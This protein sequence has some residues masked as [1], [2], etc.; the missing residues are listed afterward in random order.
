MS[1]G[2][3]Q[4]VPIMPPITVILET[5]G[6]E[7]EGN[8]TANDETLKEELCAVVVA[9]G[10]HARDA[11]TTYELHFRI[12][13][14]KDPACYNRVLR[15][16]MEALESIGGLPR[17]L[18]L[19]VRGDFGDSVPNVVAKPIRVP[20]GLEVVVRVSS[21]VAQVT[22]PSLEITIPSQTFCFI[23][24]P[25][26]KRKINA[27][28]HPE[29]GEFEERAANVPQEKKFRPD[30]HFGQIIVDEVSEY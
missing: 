24:A 6:N 3:A 29:H 22:R 26:V 10:K 19:S 23:A 21:S 17:G 5:E 15:V 12:D 20:E 8:E 25:G 2:T 4:R 28:Q 27:Y 14:L 30:E 18:M 9:G 7:T 16:L 11:G 13:N 1:N